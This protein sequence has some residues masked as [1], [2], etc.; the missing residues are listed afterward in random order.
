MKDWPWYGH[1]FLAVIVF[2]LIFF[3]YFKPKNNQIKSL[4][5][6]RIA[7]EEEVVMLK[8]KKRQ[9]DKIEEEIVVLS[10]ILSELEAVIPKRDMGHFK[11]NAT[12]CR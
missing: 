12:A 9:L 1:L 10:R 7:T 5:D 3:V 2:G 11:K 6:E 8:A 4:K